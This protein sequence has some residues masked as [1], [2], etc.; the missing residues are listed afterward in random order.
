MCDMGSL[1]VY[2]SS[3]GVTIWWWVIEKLAKC[4]LNWL[5]EKARNWVN[6][7]LQ[8]KLNVIDKPRF[9]IE[10]ASDESAFLYLDLH[11]NS[12]IASRLCPELVVLSI[13]VGEFAIDISWERKTEELSKHLVN[14]IPRYGDKWWGFYIQVPIMQL[15]RYLSKKWSVDFKAIFQSNF[16]KTFKNINFK[17]RDADAKRIREMN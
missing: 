13:R 14:D 17:I 5:K 16:T 15:K 7:E 4:G 3:L 6:E 11:L 1:F 8:S 2:I 12:K 10:K 9:Y